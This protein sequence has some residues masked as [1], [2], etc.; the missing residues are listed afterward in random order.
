MD[1]K[2]KIIV[3]KSELEAAIKKAVSAGMRESSDEHLGNANI[4]RA[5]I[6]GIVNQL[7]DNAQEVSSEPAPDTVPL[8]KYNKLLG[9]LKE[10]AEDIEDWGSYAPDFFQ[11][12]HNLAGDIAK[13]RAIIAEAEG[14]DR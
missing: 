12:K 11:E 8:E 2:D 5:D 9:A 10:A 13:Y 7:L 3:S 14:K 1:D 4:Q 6:D